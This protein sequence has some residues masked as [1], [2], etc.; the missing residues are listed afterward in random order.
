MTSPLT[1]DQVVEEFVAA[2]T[3]VGCRVERVDAAGLEA[4]L[5][6]LAGDDVVHLH[7][8]V[9]WRPADADMIELAADDDLASLT[10]L[11]VVVTEARSG[12]AETGSVLLVSPTRSELL[13]ET[14]ARHLVVF[15]DPATITADLPEVDGLVDASLGEGVVTLLSGPSRTADIERRLTI[16]VQGPTQLSIVLSRHEDP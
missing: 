16:G 11:A 6:D 14:W 5:V 9:G 2:A 1:H 7:P 8:S 13:A 12:V 3:A 4:F 10:D 15:L